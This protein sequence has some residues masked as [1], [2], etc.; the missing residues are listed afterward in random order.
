MDQVK[1]IERPFVSVQQ[2]KRN[3]IVTSLPA[4]DVTEISY[5]SVRGRD[6]EEGAVQRVLNPL[7]IASL[8]DYAIAGGDYS[9][10]IVLNW[11]NRDTAPSYE[12]SIVKLPVQPRAAQIID[13][14]HR[15]EGLREAIRVDP[16]VGKIDIPVAIYSFLETQACADIFLAINNEQ[17]PVP[18]SL[19]I[20]LYGIASP[21]LVDPASVRA[22]DIASFLNTD[23]DSPYLN[24]I[25]FPG[26]LRS[27]IGVDLSTVTSAI[28]PLVEDKG[29]L[30]SVGIT[31]F[32]IQKR[33]LTNFLA[34]L[35]SWYG[36]TW[37]GKDNVF[38]SAA[39]FTGAIDF[40]R[41]KLVPYC[42]VNR[43]YKL[44]FMTAAMNLDRDYLL[45]RSDLKGLQGRNAARQ[46]TDSLTARFRPASQSQDDI[47][48]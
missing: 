31:E 32:E 42:N 3:F 22:R 27:Q 16:S 12:G 29:A 21:T 18:K 10:S 45:K 46:V 8:R 14:Q 36:P 44:E 7:R 38:L 6:T 48:F 11:M 2:K 33:V 24:L 34:V 43:N 5:V 9:A 13:G 26:A 47:K 37:G 30:D 28:K 1:I 19:V 4:A 40:F 35:K 25:R 41:N 17:K 23:E 20:D 15:V 39:G